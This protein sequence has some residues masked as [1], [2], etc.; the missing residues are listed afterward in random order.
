MAITPTN[1]YSE[2]DSIAETMSD[3]KRNIDLISEFGIKNEYEV[4][5]RGQA[6]HEWGLVSSLARNLNAATTLDDKLLNRV[7]QA[8]LDEASNWIFEFQTENISLPLGK[9]AF[10]QHYGIPTRLIDF[11][12]KPWMSVFFAAESH[13]DV[14]GRIF[15]ILVRKEDVLKTT[16][17]DTPWRQYKTDTIKIFDPFS[18]GIKFPR[19]QAQSGVLALGRLP[20]TRPHRKAKDVVLNKSRS[21]L[22]EEVRKILSIPFKLI[23]FDPANLTSAVP[24]GATTPI[25]LTFRLHV[26]KE[27]IRRDLSG[28]EVGR[29][30]SPREMAATHKSVYPDATGMV[31]H[32]KILKGLEK[33]VLVL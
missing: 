30:I 3:I 33:G 7:E 22:A 8:L 18:A 14:D 17:P 29:R 4:F 1:Y 12:A 15:A 27:S 11:T 21:L 23:K 9:L 20:S 6:N 10:L 5:W 28:A 26:D 2:C 16:P 31:K 25:G 32:S 24:R 19:L 13:D